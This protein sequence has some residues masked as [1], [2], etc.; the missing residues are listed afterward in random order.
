MSMPIANGPS[1][2][3]VRV[4]SGADV[5]GSASIPITSMHGAMVHPGSSVG[6]AVGESEGAPP[7]VSVASG[8]RV[9]VGVRV[10]DGRALGVAVR[11]N[12]Q[13]LGVGVSLELLGVR[14]L[15]NG[16][17]PV[18]LGVGVAVGVSVIATCG[19]TPEDARP[20]A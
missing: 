11:V 1:P 16:Q 6:V 15:L 2:F 9:G 3:T 14:S 20:C 8:V 19:S 7:G 4:A 17:S 10:N 13:G 18:E 12:E 5:D